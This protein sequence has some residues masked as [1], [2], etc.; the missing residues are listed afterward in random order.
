MAMFK[1]WDVLPDDGR[2]QWVLDPL[3]GV[4][5]L[6]F[7]MSPDEVSEAL[8]H[9]TAESQRCTR[10]RSAQETVYRVE[11]G[12][13]QEFGLKLYYQQQRLAGVVVD[14]LRGPQ[15]FADGTALVGRAPS[16]LEQWVL[17]RADGRESGR[18]LSYMAAGVPVSESLGVV[19]DVQRAG[20]HLLT[21]PVFVPSEA[22]DDLPHFLPASAWSR[23]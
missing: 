3:I 16:V 6:S 7:G 23:C 15:V 1:W 2:Q 12:T 8:S 10:S 14:A 17:D 18:G 9:V 22:M 4:G 20:D 5:P 19:I 13:Y 21:R 11:V